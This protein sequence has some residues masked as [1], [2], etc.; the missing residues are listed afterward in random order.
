M[1][2]LLEGEAKFESG[3][4]MRLEVEVASG[5]TGE[6]FYQQGRT[7]QQHKRE[8]NLGGYQDAS[9]SMAGRR[10][11]RAGGLVQSS[12]D[13]LSKYR[14]RGAQ[15]EDHSGDDGSDRGKQQHGQIERYMR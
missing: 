12:R 4:A 3:Q 13:I 8:S 7:T 6:A 1:P 11:R 14:Q 15:A 10:S 5:E 2:E 9:E